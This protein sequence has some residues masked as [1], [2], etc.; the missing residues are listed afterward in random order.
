MLPGN[1]KEIDNS[2]QTPKSNILRIVLT[3]HFEYTATAHNV[4]AWC[5]G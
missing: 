4:A 1:K 5:S 3:Y 2:P